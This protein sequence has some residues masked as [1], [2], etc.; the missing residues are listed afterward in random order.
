MSS[1]KEIIWEYDNTKLS[2]HEKNKWLY[3]ILT[4]IKE[5]NSTHRLDLMWASNEKY[6]NDNIPKI[7]HKIA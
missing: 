7:D 1:Y 2:F 5:Q 3:I 6:H 4:L